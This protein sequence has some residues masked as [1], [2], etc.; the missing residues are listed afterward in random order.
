M[1]EGG[2][3]QRILEPDKEAVPVIAGAAVSEAKAKMVGMSLADLFAGIGAADD[4]FHALGGRAQ[5]FRPAGDMEG[6][7]LFNRAFQ[8]GRLRRR[9]RSGT[10]SQMREQGPERRHAPLIRDSCRRRIV[11]FPIVLTR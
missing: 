3:G 5:A 10:A 1:V 4:Q 6:A 7:D 8:H 9:G 11:H 2:F